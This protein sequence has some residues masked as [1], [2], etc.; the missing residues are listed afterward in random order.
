MGEVAWP[1]CGVV[2]ITVDHVVST[3]VLALGTRSPRARV[4]HVVAHHLLDDP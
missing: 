1:W 4:E 3:I 2:G